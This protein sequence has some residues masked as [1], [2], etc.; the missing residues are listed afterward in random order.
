MTAQAEDIEK[1]YGDARHT[2]FSPSQ[3][4]A[5]F[6]LSVDLQRAKGKHTDSLVGKAP[7]TMIHSHSPVIPVCGA[8]PQHQT[9]LLVLK[10]IAVEHLRHGYEVYVGTSTWPTLTSSPCSRDERS[11]RIMQQ[12]ST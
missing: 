10:K 1:F 3:I 12:L 8:I 7:A 4:R 9:I 11:E 5:D 2:A 6:A